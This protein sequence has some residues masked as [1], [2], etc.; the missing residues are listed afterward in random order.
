VKLLER[1]PSLT[2]IFHTDDFAEVKRY[3]Y[4]FHRIW[5]YIRHQFKRQSVYGLHS[6]FVY[7]F[8]IQVLRPNNFS[9]AE[10]MWAERIAVYRSQ[11]RTDSSIIERTEIGAGS[12]FHAHSSSAAKKIAV[13]TVAQRSACSTRKG[14]FLF[15]VTAFHQPTAMLELGGNLGL[16]AFYQQAAAPQSTVVSIEGVG[17]YVAIAQRGASALQLA[18]KWKHSLFDPAL[19]QLDLSQFQQVLIDGDHR[20]EATMRYAGV[21]LAN[22]PA[23][24]LIILDDIYWSPEMTRAWHELILHP[25]V[26][27][28]IDLYDYGLLWLD[29]PRQ[30]AHFRLARP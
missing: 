19:Q 21:L 24:A 28:S 22:L 4:A 16:S 25:R 30:K 9:A 18:P 13:R 12:S 5:C 7:T 1:P 14:R 17:A 20:Y 6:P 11:L 15:R 29:L 8:Y 3:R 27:L 2:N 23:G 10:L 26:R